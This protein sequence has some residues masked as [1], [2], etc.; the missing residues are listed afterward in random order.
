MAKGEDGG[1]CGML[2]SL[3][4]RPVPAGRN[5]SG[6]E[7][8]RRWRRVKNYTSISCQPSAPNLPPLPTFRPCLPYSPLRSERADTRH[9]IAPEARGGRQ[10]AQ[11]PPRQSRP[12]SPSWR[13]RAETGSFFDLEGWKT[14]LEG[15]KTWQE[16]R[17]VYTAST[18]ERSSLE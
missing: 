2:T 16:M 9:Q 11:L 8:R 15:W 18:P 5:S 14:W 10:N 7:E 4:R 3:R 1:K 6:G 17:N 13:E 12:Y